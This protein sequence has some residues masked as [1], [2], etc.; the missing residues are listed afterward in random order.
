MERYV[1]IH[2]ALALGARLTT[3]VCLCLP[4]SVAD[5]HH[6]YGTFFDLCTRITI[7]GQ[8]Q[9]V[10]W[11]S[12]HI[13]LDVKADDGTVHHAEWTGPRNLE[14]AGVLSGLQG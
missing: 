9:S 1:T 3:A 11:K 4:A 6:S 10:Q 13:W 14:V 5:A 12:P 2:R 7:E 8:V